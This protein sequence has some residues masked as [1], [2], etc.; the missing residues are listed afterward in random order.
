MN[1]LFEIFKT[2]LDDENITDINYNGKTL[3][4]DHLKKGRYQIEEFEDDGIEQFCFQIA[5]QL[6]LPFNV[7][8]PLLEAESEQM[9][10]SML[11]PSVAKSGYSISIRKTPAI[12]R[13]KRSTLIKE[14]YASAPLLD[15]LKL[16]VENQCNIMTVSY[17][18][19]A[20]DSAICLSI[21]VYVPFPY[22]PLP[23]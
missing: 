6:N 8:H 5:N 13:L 3:W 2:F 17:T 9:R 1:A 22:T 15:F 19:L 11:H 23:Q 21:S 12:M 14:K 4:V 16:A 20:Y 10:I 7:T 18:H